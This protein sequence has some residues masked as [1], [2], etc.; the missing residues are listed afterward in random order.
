MKRDGNYLRGDNWLCIDPTRPD[1]HEAM[2][3]ARYE[4]PTCVQ[5][6]LLLAAAEMYIHLAT[7]PAGS[8]S[9]VRK[10]RMIRRAVRR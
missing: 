6:G 2:H 1:L 5:V 4:S 9:A 7:H 3:A 10:L 8:E